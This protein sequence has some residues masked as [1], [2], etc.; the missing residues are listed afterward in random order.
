[1]KKKSLLFAKYISYLFHPILMPSIGLVYLYLS[2]KVN[3]FNFYSSLDQQQ[4]NIMIFSVTTTFSLLI[5]AILIYYLKSINKIN[6]YQMSQKEE[7]LLPFSLMFLCFFAAYYLLFDYGNIQ[8]EPIIKIFFF[9]C[10]LSVL[11]ALII[12]FKWKI[13]VHMIGIG[14]LT[15]AVFLVHQ[16]VKVDQLPAL[17]ITI[18]TAGVI[19]YSR[20]TLNAHSLK[21]VAAGYL[22]GFFCET[23]FLFFI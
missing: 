4:D 13:S 15:G 19:G 10:L 23:C 1:M 9:G 18:L 8:A 21:Q 14:G 7:R 2:K 17:I 20:L 5:P 11:F 12:T 22:L 6:S 3:H 16:I